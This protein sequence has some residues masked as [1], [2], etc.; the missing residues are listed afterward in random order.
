MLLE[1]NILELL[2]TP[3]ALHASDTPHI[4]KSLL[5]NVIVAIQKY[6]SGVRL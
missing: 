5:L 2:K 4:L 6:A 3:N 1:K